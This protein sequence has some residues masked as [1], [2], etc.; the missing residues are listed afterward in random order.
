MNELRRDGRELLA[1]ARR[2]RTPDADSR[3]RVFA[4]V[5]ASVAQASAAGTRRPES[6]PLT[7]I[8]RWLVL[9]ALVAA[10]TGALYCAAHA[11]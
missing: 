3:E 6:K 5:L 1:E 4:A 11:H 10:V 9:A 7:G 8:R 2:E